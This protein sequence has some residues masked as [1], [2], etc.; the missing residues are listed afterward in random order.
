MSGREYPDR[1]WIG[2]G[3]IAF[4]G[5]DVLLVRRGK[6]P[7]M[8]EWSIPGGAQSLGERAE[9]TA[10]RELREEAGIEVGPLTLAA[11]VDALDYD[12]AGRPRFHYTIIDFAGEWTGGEPWAGDDV[13]EARWFTPEELPS[14]GLWAEALRV[15]EEGRRRLAGLRPA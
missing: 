4:H 9:D 15:I 10:R 14:L 6:P 7:R 13:T 11:V 2:V 8:G 3:L 12:E 1:P 5:Q